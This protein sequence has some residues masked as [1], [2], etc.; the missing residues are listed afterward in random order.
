MVDKLLGVVITI[1]KVIK[2]LQVVSNTVYKGVGQVNRSKGRQSIILKGP[3]NIITY[4]KHMGGVYH[5]DHRRLTSTGFANASNFKKWYKKV[6]AT[7]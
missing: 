5:G 2:T 1:W 4:Q 6:F 3:N 7:F